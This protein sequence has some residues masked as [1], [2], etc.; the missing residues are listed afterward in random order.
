[1]NVDLTATDVRGAPMTAPRP[2]PLPVP[3][4]TTV[5][6]TSDPIVA[7]VEPDRC[8]AT[9]PPVAVRTR[10]VARDAV[11]LG[12]VL[13]SSVALGY[14]ISSPARS[15]VHNRMLPWILGRSLGVASYLTLTALVLLGLWLRHPLRTRAWSPRPESLLRG[16]VVLAASTVVLL[17]GHVTSIALD[18]YAGVGWKGALVPGHAHYRPTAVAVGTVALYALVLVGGTAALAGAIGSRIWFPIHVVSATVFCL[19]LVH[20]VLAGSDGNALRWL[21]VGTGALVVAVQ[22]TRWSARYANGRSQGELE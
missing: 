6:A 19:C 7:V 17:V 21:Y 5:V 2:L 13:G 8:V 1:M 18:R 12:V 15:L 22:I 11:L 4:L 14:E 9:D 20:G 3:E 16:H 10:R